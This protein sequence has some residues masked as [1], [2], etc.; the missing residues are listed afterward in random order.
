VAVCLQSE[1][2]ADGFKPS[3][4]SMS[5]VY[6]QAGKLICCSSRGNFVHNHFQ[7]FG[8][9]DQNREDADESEFE[10]FRA[11]TPDTLRGYSYEILDQPSVEFSRQMWW[12]S[13]MRYYGGPRTH[14]TRCITDDLSHLWVL[15]TPIS[16]IWAEIFRVLKFPSLQF[17]GC[18][19]RC[20]M[21]SI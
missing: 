15:V 2:L 17:H 12:E 10:E 20:L 9:D 8:N 13:L 4:V 21:H 7:Y 1:F 18:I 11:P 6:D 14:A 16:L 3:A 19:V 5:S